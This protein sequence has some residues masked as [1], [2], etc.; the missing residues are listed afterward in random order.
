M[1]LRYGTPYWLD[2]ARSRDVPRF[3]RLRSNLNSDV[4]IIGGGFTG[5]AAAHTFASAGIDVV[6]LDRAR[7][8]HGSASAST[9]L[10]MQ[11]TD[12][13]FIELRRRYGLARARTIWRVSAQSV[14]DLVRLAT[15]LNCDLQFARS[16]QIARDLHGVR[17]LRR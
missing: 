12:C 1:R 15:T 4:V 2:D 6:V 10:L 7:L 16:L 11:E 13:S 3:A 17:Q 8:G 5:C 14:A 9:A